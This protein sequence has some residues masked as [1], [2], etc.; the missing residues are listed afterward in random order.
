MEE[1]LTDDILWRQ[2]RVYREAPTLGGKPGELYLYLDGSDS[3]MERADKLIPPLG[4][5]VD[6]KDAERIHSKLK[7]EQDNAA[8]GMGLMFAD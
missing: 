2:S 7:E 6:M 3:A 1:V 4:T 8:Q 5:K